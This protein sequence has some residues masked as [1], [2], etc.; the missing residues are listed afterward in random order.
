MGWAKGI[1][2]AWRGLRR[3]PGYTL[4]AV[5]TIA[6]GVGGN[7]AMFSLIH[8]VLLTPLDYPEPER[9]V[10][11]GET[12]STPGQLNTIS[13][14]ESYALEELPAL[15]EFAGVRT[16]RMALTGAGPAE[17]VIGAR[18][19]DGLLSILGVTP[20][21][22]RD[23]LSVEARD[24]SVARVVLSHGL[25]QSR[26][27]GDPEVVGR[28][29]TLDGIAHEIVGV[30]P[31]GFAY[32]EDAGFWVP[33][34]TRDG[35]CWWGCNI[36]RGVGRL[37]SGATVETLRGQ[38]DALSRR[39]EAEHP[40]QQTSRR[41]EVMTLQEYRVGDA[42]RGLWI[43]LGAVGVVLLIAC[44]NVAHLMLARS[45]DRRSEMSLRVAL[46]ASRMDLF[47]SVMVESLLLAGL[48]AILGVG[49]AALVLGALPAL[50]VD[51]VPRL[52]NVR[53]SLPVLGFTAG[54][55]LASAVGFGLLPAIQ[56]ARQGSA[57]RGHLSRRGGGWGR[58]R[59]LRDLLLGG[60]IALALVLLV[61]AG[62]LLR[63]FA[64]LARVD[65]GYVVEDVVRFDIS[66]P[67]GVYDDPAEVQAFVDEL[68]GGLAGLPG[69]RSVALGMGTPLS[70][71][72]VG[73]SLRFLDRPEPEPGEG[74]T[75]SVLVVTPGYFD[76]QDIEVVRGRD[77]D[78][79]ERYGEPSAF[80]VNQAFVRRYLADRDDP[81]GT[82]VRSGVGFGFERQPGDIV[83]IVEDVRTGGIQREADPEIYFA[84]AQFLPTFF[85]VN[86]RLEEGAP[87]P[88]GIREVL[89][90]VDPDVPLFR[91]GTIEE[92]VRSEL[93]SPRFYLALLSIFAALAV[94]LAAVGVY[95]VVAYAVGRR[96]R[97]I[98]VRVAMGATERGI[99]RLVLSE[100]LRPAVIGVVV[101]VSAAVVATRLL[102]SLLYGVRPLDPLT[103]SGVTLLLL[104]VSAFAIVVP[105]RRAAR[106]DP[107]EALHVE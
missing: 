41:F 56:T 16:S 81:L 17:T 66:L 86:L 73:G 49:F 45:Q 4:V 40:R 12:S 104:G 67:G 60:E 52:E 34:G 43:L 99:L 102:E 20:E 78:G 71:Y 85:T 13:A 35:D 18:V 36:M 75:A 54:V 32:P 61:G 87:V 92:A 2:F 84:H 5:V 27:G 65:P 76:L 63:T 42:A 6:L 15:E 55:A 72:S 48:A 44:A 89:V 9:L 37:A 31:A 90:D 11:V 19:T 64:T 94:I 10:A 69:V 47:Q 38:T 82:P 95:G 98:G 50:A 22:G 70:S 28:T 59:R 21:L 33:G 74:P 8:G 91:L 3:R 1:R 106:L 58:G 77:F 62:L 103:F 88:S 97:E 83:G 51:A 80:L 25:W 14:P 105:A 7:T 57:L 46:G 39:L 23:L 100:G 53:L 96:T 101:G 24:A 26:F 107:V 93:A 79:T 30:A 68:Q 29:V